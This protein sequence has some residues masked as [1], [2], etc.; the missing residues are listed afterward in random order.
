LPEAAPPAGPTASPAPTRALPPVAPEE[1]GAAG[2]LWVVV[3]AA[4][5]AA[6]VT[7]WSIRGRGRGR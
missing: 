6:G 2:W 1:D 7:V 5:L 4:V 3:G